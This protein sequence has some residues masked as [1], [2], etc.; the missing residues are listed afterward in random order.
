[1]KE[2]SITVGGIKIPL[3]TVDSELYYGGNKKINTIHLKFGDVIKG[4]YFTP[5]FCKD[6]KEFV[7]N[8][9]DY[10]LKVSNREVLFKNALDVLNYIKRHNIPVKLY[11]NYED[12]AFYNVDDAIR[13]VEYYER[14]RDDDRKREGRIESCNSTGWE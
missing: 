4:Y 12:A 6:Y 5:K 14:E 2:K 3:K 11:Q 13:Y 7:D 1:M 9:T 8:Y 10:Y